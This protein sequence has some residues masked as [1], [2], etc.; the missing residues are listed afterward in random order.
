MNSSS[1][2]SVL[3]NNE[4]TLS[5]VGKMWCNC[6][7]CWGWVSLKK[8]KNPQSALGDQWWVL[9]VDPKTYRDINSKLKGPRNA[10]FRAALSVA[11]P[12]IYFTPTPHWHCTYSQASTYSTSPHIASKTSVT[13]ASW[14]PATP[15]WSAELAQLLIP[16]LCVCVCV[17]ELCRV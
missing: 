5:P 1:L 4:N 2:C 17:C 10:P 11:W 6:C 12:S 15:F 13:C 7:S 16:S 9:G 8:K 3:C 14:P